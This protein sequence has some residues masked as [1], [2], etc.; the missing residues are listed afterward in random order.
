MHNREGG[1]NNK[2]TAFELTPSDGGR[3]ETVLQRSASSR[4]CEG[5]RA[6]LSLNRDDQAL[7]ERS[8]PCLYKAEQAVR[9]GFQR[10]WQ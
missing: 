4:K 1:V 3:T 7:Q 9:P 6:G 5:S 8:I 2:G 10:V